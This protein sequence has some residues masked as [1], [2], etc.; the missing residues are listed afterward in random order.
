MFQRNDQLFG[1]GAATVALSL[2]NAIAFRPGLPGIADRLR[3][4]SDQLSGIDWV[5]DLGRDIGSLQWFRGLATCALLCSSAIALSPGFRPLPG[6]APAPLTGPAWDEARSQTI[7]PLAFGGDTGSRMAANDMVRELADIP[8]RPTIELVATFGQ[9]DGLA[10]VLERAGV[11]GPEARYVTGLVAD[12]AG[13]DQI[14]P[15]TRIPVTLGPRNSRSVPRP[16]QALDL[17]ARFDLNLSFRRIGGSL[18]MRRVPIA[19]DNTPLRIRGTVGDSLYRS[20]R[21]AGVPAKAIEAYLRTI[22]GKVSLGSDVPAS[23]RFDLIVEQARADT[24]EVKFG[25]LL[26]AGLERGNRNLQMIPW[27]VGG[28]TDWFDAAGVGKQRAGMTP[29]VAGARMSS[30]F[31]MRF[32]PILG[33]SRFH[34]GVDYAAGYGTPIRAVTDGV[35]A[36]AGRSGGHGNHI[37]INHAGGLASGYSHLSRYAVSSGVRVVQG[38]VIGYVGSTGLSTGPHLHFEVYRNGAPVNPRSVAFAS[39]SLLSGKELEAFRSRLRG[40]LETPVTG[41][42]KAPQIAA[43]Q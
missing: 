12:A 22:A 19:V 4:R 11:S 10:R 26:Y 30:G 6:H 13:L 16:L 38:Q 37:R 34:R 21:A 36:F 2:D 28:R 14:A 29:P 33:Y 39:S 3:L 17:R 5:P 8:E 40:L 1:S 31:G 32:H 41:A 9:G 35:V 15:G 25:Q 43:R 18:E 24:G 27:T 42:A 7:A 20:A 23:S